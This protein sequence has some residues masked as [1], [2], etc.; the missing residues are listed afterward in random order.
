MSTENKICLCKQISEETI[1]SAI[2][3]GATTVE[4]VKEKTGATDGPCKGARC[5]QKIEALIEEHK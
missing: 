1:I 2:K 3:D 4:A 5:K